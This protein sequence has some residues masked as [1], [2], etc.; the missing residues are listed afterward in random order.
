MSS[1]VL[2]DS[3][4]RRLSR[5]DLK[6]LGLSALGGALEFYDFIVFVF[7]TAALS[8]LFFSPEQSDWLKQMQVYGLFAAAYLA[9]PLGGII[10]AH[11]GDLVGRK[12]MFTFSIF[13]MAVPTFLMGILPTYADIGF[14][15]PVLMLVLRIVQG[16]AV[17]GEVPGA[18]VFVSEHVPRRHIGFA[19]GTLTAGLTLG[20]LIGSLVATFINS[21]LTP[22]Q[23]L[24]YGWRAAFVLG[25]VFGLLGVYLRRYLSET[26]VFEEMR[27]RKALASEMPVKTVLTSHPGPVVFSM[28]LT[29]MLTA[30]I[31]VVIL[32]TPSILQSQFGISPMAA[33]EANT[34]AVFCLTVGCVLA[35]AAA[36][37]YGPGRTFIAGSVLL[38]AAVYSLYANVGT[39]PSRLMSLYAV[40]GFTVGIVG[41]VPYVMVRAFPPAV[42]FSG[43]SFSYNVAYAIFGG[44]TPMA[45]AAT[46]EQAS[47][48][49]AYYVMGTCL[50]GLGAGIYMIV[51]GWGRDG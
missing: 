3:A 20:I 4:N 25:G 28:L 37:R 48:A 7:F 35:G 10:M 16:A 51:T 27:A 2:D 30:A 11:F 34:V 41:A 47:L 49:P 14:W 17:G 1:T 23:V 26:P 18:W 12:R 39:D 50:I 36:D 43:L 33:L 29:W 44:L 19:C 13:L 32:M 24:D 9:R 31:V 15:A 45:V 40:A 46:L 6:T 22:Q 38:A 5:G 21:V 42:R 8:Q